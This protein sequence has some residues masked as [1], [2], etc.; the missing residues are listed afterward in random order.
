MDPGNGIKP[1]AEG[2]ACSPSPAWNS[3][4][5]MDSSFLMRLCEGGWQNVIVTRVY[6]KKVGLMF[7]GAN[8]K[9]RYL[10]DVVTPFEPNAPTVRWSERYLVMKENDA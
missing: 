9:H 10:D 5:D 7:Q 1:V 2:I 4:S 8:P 6:K 3:E